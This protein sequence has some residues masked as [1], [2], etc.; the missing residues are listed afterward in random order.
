MSQSNANHTHLFCA[1]FV[2]FSMHYTQKLE[3]WTNGDVRFSRG[4]TRC[5]GDIRYLNPRGFNHSATRA[6]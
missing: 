2:K 4:H 3:C 1:I 5:R 6:A